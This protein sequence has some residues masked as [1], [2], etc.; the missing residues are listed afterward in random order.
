MG[1]AVVREKM[2]AIA[3]RLRARAN[4]L[5]KTPTIEKQMT[6]GDLLNTIATEIEEELKAEQ[7]SKSPHAKYILSDLPEG[8]H[9]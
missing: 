5:D 6:P 1:S 8:D 9:R 4:E 2:I 3:G 7:L